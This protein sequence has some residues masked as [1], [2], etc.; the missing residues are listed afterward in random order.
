MHIANSMDLRAFVDHSVLLSNRSCHEYSISYSTKPFFSGLSA[1]QLPQEARLRSHHRGR[2]A[3]RMQTSS[4]SSSTAAQDFRSRTQK[5]MEKIS[6]GSEVGGAGGALSYQALKRL[7]QLWLAIRTKTADASAPIEVV[8][9]LSGSYLGTGPNPRRSKLFD[10]IICGGTLGIFVAMALNLR[11]LHVGVIEKSTLKGRVQEWNISK[12]ELME[13]VNIGILSEDDIGKVITATFN[14][15]R[16]GFK[17]RG[18]VWVEDILNLGVSPMQ[19][20]D[21]VKQ[22][23]LSSG[24]MLFEG[25]GVSNICVY[26]DATVIKLDNGEA[27][28]A[29]LIVDAMGNFSPIVRQI[30]SEQK[31]DGVCLVVGS[32][33]RGYKENS[34]S[35]IIYTNLPAIKVG[36]SRLQ[37]FW[38]AFPAGSGPRDRT[39]YL[40][41]YV[42]A[43]PNR[44]SLEK[45]LEDYW[46]L[47]P[48]YQ[49]V[50]LDDLE[51]LRVVFG[52]FP[53]YRDSPLPA[54]FD[55]ILQVGDASGIQSP[56]SFGGFGSIS[57]HLG[58][59]STGIHEAITANLLDSYSLS[60]LNPYMPNLSAAWLF[61]KAM[62]AQPYENVSPDFIND[63]L[64]ANFK[65]M[66]RLGDPVLRPF[67][68]DV[69][70]FKP[71]AKSLGLIMLTYP[72]LLPSIFYQVGPLAILDWMFHFVALGS[73][74]FLSSFISPI[75]RSWVNGLPQKDKYI[76][77]R[78][79]E[80]WKY[81]S[82]LD[83][84]P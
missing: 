26:D 24:G 30:R 58:R 9:R 80:A 65:C 82:G 55:R 11:G 84:K 50:R 2:S 4:T 42:D 76:W 6:I 74:T 35:D 49:G 64:S 57:R 21:L 44:P 51:I 16:C 15:N 45:M 70:Q 48:D 39:I 23:F 32:C 12:K 1:F 53:T 34:T 28:D 75:L 33:G 5:I 59:L 20:I 13:L 66:Q 31:P 71:L 40:F 69:I 25:H 18:E 37:Y 7:D 81:G 27:L 77:N 41:T 60:L 52:I 83:Y 79:L 46:D 38:E 62:S 68:Q 67:L 78:R 63:L 3:V 29:R 61:Q 56:V 47:M 17:G 43:Q 19:L 54:A 14:P 10:V 8:K 22:R 36:E 73:Y 72:Q